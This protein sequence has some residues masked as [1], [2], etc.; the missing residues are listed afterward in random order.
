[1][2]LGEVAEFGPYRVTFAELRHWAWF[3]VVYDPGYIWI[4]IAFALC[5]AGLSHRFIYTEK[6]LSVKVEPQDD[7]ATVSLAGH[8]RYFPALF[9]REIED[10]R[11]QLL[12]EAAGDARG[13]DAR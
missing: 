12:P 8:S 11:K 13:G 7:A 2:T 3:G 1:M 4:V 9:E 6:W 5:V 10:I